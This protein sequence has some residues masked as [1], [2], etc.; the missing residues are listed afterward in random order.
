MSEV[1]IPDEVK[2]RS[3]DGAPEADHPEQ[4]SFDYST[5]GRRRSFE[6]NQ[7][8]LDLLASIKLDAARSVWT[9]AK[10]VL[11][12]VGTSIFTAILLIVPI[13]STTFVIH[14]FLPQ[15]GW[16]S[17]EQQ[18]RL[19]GWYS[20]VSQAAF[21]VILVVNSWLVWLASRRGSRQERD[22]D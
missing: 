13:M 21:P 11:R 14:M 12:I 7:E 16:L 3:D 15:A 17:P 18:S 5:Y 8:W 19:T 20:E 1:R 4:V 10:P 2:S 22:S 6:R 9:L